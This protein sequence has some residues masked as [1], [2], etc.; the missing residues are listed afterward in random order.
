MIFPTCMMKTINHIH[1]M[2]KPP[3]CLTKTEQGFPGPIFIYSPSKNNRPGQKGNSSQS[4]WTHTTRQKQNLWGRPTS[5][6]DQPKGAVRHPMAWCHTKYNRLL[7]V[8]HPSVF[9][10]WRMFKIWV[11][12]LNPG[13]S[14]NSRTW[15]TPLAHQPDTKAD[16]TLWGMISNQ[17]LSSNLKK[18]M[19]KN[20][21]K[22]NFKP[23]WHF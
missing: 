10:L 13:P 9:P 16:Q 12:R 1:S 4:N 11:L 17:Y 6:P 22:Q 14:T 15:D 23:R 2:W 5:P 19:D 18:W 20:K 8:S 7:P 3:F 21:Q